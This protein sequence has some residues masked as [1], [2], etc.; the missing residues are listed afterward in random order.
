MNCEFILS[1]REIAQRFFA[2]IPPKQQNSNSFPGI[3]ESR[4]EPSKGL[5]AIPQSSYPLTIFYFKSKTFKRDK[6]DFVTKNKWEAMSFCML[7]TKTNNGRCV[8]CMIL[9]WTELVVYM[10]VYGVNINF[11]GH[12]QAG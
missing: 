3:V 11:V 6:F 7:V 9:L 2:D 12:N 10:F 4:T 5:I 8:M 1:Q